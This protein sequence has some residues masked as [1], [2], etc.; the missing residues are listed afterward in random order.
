[1]ENNLCA[2]SQ[3]NFAFAFM[4]PSFKIRAV[5][6]RY[7]SAADISRSRFFDRKASMA[8]RFLTPWAFGDIR[9]AR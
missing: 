2:F 3:A 9:A 6:P 4:T 7:S 1:G 8:Q 5:T